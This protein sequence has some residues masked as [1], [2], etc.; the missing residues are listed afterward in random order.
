MVTHKG[1]IEY[2]EQKRCSMR[3]C[4]YVRRRHEPYQGRKGH[5]WTQKHGYKLQRVH[6]LQWI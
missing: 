3:H 6:P 4:P 5:R 1:F 2:M